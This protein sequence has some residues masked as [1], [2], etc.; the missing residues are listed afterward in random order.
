MKYFLFF[1]LLFLSANPSIA[2]TKPYTSIDWLYRS[3][4]MVGNEV[5]RLGAKEIYKDKNLH[6][7]FIV[8][9]NEKQVDTFSILTDDFKKGEYLNKLFSTKLK[10][11]YKKFGSEFPTSYAEDTLSIRQI[12]DVT[13]EGVITE[14]S[15]EIILEI[16]E[17]LSQNPRQNSLESMFKP[18]SVKLSDESKR[19]LEEQMLI[20]RIKIKARKDDAIKDIEQNSSDF[21]SNVFDVLHKR[22]YEGPKVGVL[23]ISDSLKIKHSSKDNCKCRFGIVET[24]SDGNNRQSED[25]KHSTEEYKDTIFYLK[26]AEMKFEAG[27]IAAIKVT[28]YVNGL[29]NKEVLFHNRIPIS[30]ST[31]FDVS[32]DFFLLNN[33]RIFSATHELNDCFIYFSDLLYNDYKLSNYTN[34]YSPIDTVIVLRPNEAGRIIF[35]ERITDIFQARIFSDFL[36]YDDKNPNGLVQVE[37]SKRIN[38]QTFARPMMVFRSY[39]FFRYV[40]PFVSFT[41]LEKNQK[42]LPTPPLIIM[43][44]S[45]VVSETGVRTIDLL[46]YSNFMSGGQINIIT[47]EKPEYHSSFNIDASLNVM[48]TGI[49]TTTEEQDTVGTTYFQAVNN[50]KA[51][52]LVF[53][54]VILGWNIYPH[55]HY[56]ISFNYRMLLISELNTNIYQLDKNRGGKFLHQLGL[57]GGLRPNENGNGEIFFRVLFNLNYRHL[58]QNYLQGQIGYTFKVFSRK[59]EIRNRPVFTYP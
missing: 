44:D 46:R 9:L 55:S 2:Q 5:L 23:Y 11:A 37:M 38:V 58:N 39:Q 53:T 6:Y 43:Q 30:Y 25:N 59:P 19:W 51:V 1:T 4:F 50:S 47:F 18:L 35:R 34:N 3:D 20:S 26:E 15:K 36:G 32:H 31:K 14:F 52:S 28:G 24:I 57:V 7:F 12:A 54:P 29:R 13:I 10:E 40:I 16:L 56:S 17:R 48:L 49:S 22:V 8:S 27:Q 41:K 45:L 42:Y 21:L 33:R